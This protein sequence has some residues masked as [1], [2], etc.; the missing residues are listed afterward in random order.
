M[1]NIRKTN[2][3]V[4]EWIGLLVYWIAGRISVLFP[5]PM[6]VTLLTGA[7]VAVMAR[8][9]PCFPRREFVSPANRRARQLIAQWLHLLEN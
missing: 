3:A 4:H 9:I 5:G 1:D 7:P 6:S 2:L 8:K